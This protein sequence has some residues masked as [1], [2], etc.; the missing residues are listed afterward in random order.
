MG[1]SHVHTDCCYVFSKEHEQ[2]RERLKKRSKFQVQLL[3]QR[4]QFPFEVKNPP[5]PPT[6][7]NKTVYVSP[8]ANVALTQ[9]T[10]NGNVELRKPCTGTITNCYVIHDYD[11]AWSRD[12]K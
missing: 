8:K 4:R 9:K 3:Q 10:M 1:E 2:R 12:T 11:F 5:P 7:P 6:S